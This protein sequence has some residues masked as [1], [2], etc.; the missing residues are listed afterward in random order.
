[1]SGK[2]DEV[3]KNGEFVRVCFAYNFSWFFSASEWL[4]WLCGLVVKELEFGV[5]YKRLRGGGWLS[6]GV[7]FMRLW[8]GV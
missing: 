2:S 8:G 6:G 7:K 1:M 4:W 3:G 5:K